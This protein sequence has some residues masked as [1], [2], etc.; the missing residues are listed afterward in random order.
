[1]IEYETENMEGVSGEE[2]QVFYKV[3]L[4]LAD[5][6]LIFIRK[7]FKSQQIAAYFDVNGNG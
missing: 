3:K 2:L 5:I 1:M 7:L 4:I 6:Y